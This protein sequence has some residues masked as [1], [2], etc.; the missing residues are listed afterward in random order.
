[1]KTKLLSYGL[2]L[3][4][5]TAALLGAVAPAQAADSPAPSSGAAGKKPNI[6]FIVGLFSRISF[7]A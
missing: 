2:S 1:M 7:I 6:L 3:L 4:I 5:A